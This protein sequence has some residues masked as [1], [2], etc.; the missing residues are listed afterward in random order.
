MAKRGLPGPKYYSASRIV[1]EIKLDQPQK[2][3]FFL[4]NT[5]HDGRVESDGWVTFVPPGERI[6]V[7][8]KIPIEGGRPYLAAREWMIRRAAEDPSRPRRFSVRELAALWNLEGSL[9]LKPGCEGMLHAGVGRKVNWAHMGEA[10]EVWAAS[11]KKGLYPPYLL[12]LLDPD[13]HLPIFTRTGPDP[14]SREDRRV[15][16]SFDIARPLE[17][18]FKE[19]LK[20]LGQL[21]EYALMLAGQAP[22]R[23]RVEELRRDILIFTYRYSA[24]LSLN[25]IASRVFPSEPCESARAKVTTILRRLRKR[26]GD[27]LGELPADTWEQ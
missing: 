22:P 12:E 23:K 15:Y 1:G 10:I 16:V 13:S 25:A 21:R 3:L 6:Q 7:Q 18:Q 4:G 19:A 24:E 14:V 9:E 11:G 17:D 20:Q 26:I 8:L 27:R 5:L 2:D